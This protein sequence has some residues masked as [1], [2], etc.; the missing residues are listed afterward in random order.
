MSVDVLVVPRT[1]EQ[2]FTIVVIVAEPVI[3]YVIAVVLFIPKGQIYQS[4]NAGAVMAL[5][6]HVYEQYN[7][8]EKN[9][10][11]SMVL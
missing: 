6:K 7:Q 9:A 8:G 5:Q 10:P 3:S 4:E 1:R 11:H 2:V